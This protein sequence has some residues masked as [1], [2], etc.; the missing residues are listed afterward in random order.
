[1]NIDGFPAGARA[2]KATTL[3]WSGAGAAS[4][5]AT[6]ESCWMAV[7]MC[8]GD[9]LLSMLEYRK[10]KLPIQT[11]AFRAIPIPL[12]EDADEHLVLHIASERI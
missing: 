6:A 9:V 12:A 3:H 5:P 1:M 8:G 11:S 2:K 4:S 10:T 7:L